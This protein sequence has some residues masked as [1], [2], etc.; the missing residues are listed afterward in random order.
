MVH[1]EV[2]AEGQVSWIDKIL[3][4]RGRPQPGR[5]ALGAMAG[6]PIPASSATRPP[7]KPDRGSLLPRFQST[8]GDQLDSRANGPLARVRMQLRNAF[9]PS[10]PVLDPAMFAGRREV[11]A[12]LIRSIEDER[13][14][15]IIYGERGIGKTSLLHVLAQAGREARYLVTY[16]SC[17]AASTFDETFRAVA[18]HIPLLYHSDYGPTSKEAETGATFAD[19]LPATPVTLRLAS[20]LCAKIIGT[21]VLMVLDEFDRCESVEFRRNITEFLKNLSD[22]SVRV[23]VVIAGVAGNL[24]ELMDQGRRMNRNI[25]AFPVPKMTPPEIQE[26][27]EN[28]ERTTGLSFSEDAVQFIVSL[29]NGLP[30]FA[31][32]LGQHAG[33]VALDAGRVAVTTADVSA[34]IAEA[35][36]E[37]KTRMTRRSQ[38]Q[39]ENAVKSGAHRILGPLAG[40]AHT[41]G[42]AF[43]L[44]EVDTVFAGQDIA[45]RCGAL[46]ESMAAQGVLL[47]A[48]DDEYGRGYRFTEESIPPYLWLMAAKDQFVN[49]NAE[50]LHGAAPAQR[51]SLKF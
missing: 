13:L 9:T 25:V 7:R 18:G 2:S 35:L 49:G 17:S 22:R 12:T 48:Y 27:V 44:A 14:H 50:G 21:R 20:D 3:T 37:L 40:M 30:Y 23:Q 38:A 5:D 42:G 15:T 16:V 26:L 39:V 46:V 36:N 24:A 28:G 32:L 8:A 6:G 29:A 11:L 45:E 43:T 51:A 10:H 1:R 41:A 19:L 33:L 47:E 34:A 31:S 4:R